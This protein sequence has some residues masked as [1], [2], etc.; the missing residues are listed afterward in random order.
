MTLGS[1]DTDAPPPVYAGLKVLS[2]E[3]EGLVQY[4][5][6][7]STLVGRLKAVDVFLPD[8]KCSR[9]HCLVHWNGAGYVLV[10]VS[11]NGTW[12]NG[13]KVDK[14]SETPLNSGDM[15]RIGETQL[16]F[17]LA[18]S[19]QP[20]AA[21]APAAPAQAPASPPIASVPVLPMT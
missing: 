11:A 7:K 4:P 6:K 10:D 3:R 1:G 8:V 18:G 2:G 13:A 9:R 20:V 14:Q 12:L 16:E 17:R 5:L 19:A 15:I 21:S